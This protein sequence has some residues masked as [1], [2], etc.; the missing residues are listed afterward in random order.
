MNTISTSN[1]VILETFIT[2]LGEL[3]QLSI[4]RHADNALVLNFP[5]VS[6]HHAQL[7]V[8]GPTSFLLEDLGSKNGTFV[9]EYRCVRKI[10]DLNDRV[11]FAD[12]GMSVAEL[13]RHKKTTVEPKNAPAIVAPTA[14]KQVAAGKAGAANTPNPLDFSREF[15]ALQAVYEQYPQ[16]RKACRNRDKMIRTASVIISSIV[17]IS[18][19][20]SSGGGALPMMSVLSGAGLGI[21]IPTLSSTLLSTDEKLEVIDKEY[22][23]R[24]RCPNPACRDPFLA[25]EWP[26]LA[27]QKTCRRCKAI[28]VQ[29]E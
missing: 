1:A 10:I 16:L 13:L 20:L 8:C 24:Y 9:N 28:W 12:Q 5:K 2:Q 21:L 27:Q 14:A 22:R 18:A 23:A 25:R 11:Q 29:T 3:P 15:A 6:G 26:L 4:G 19:V 7:T 17:G